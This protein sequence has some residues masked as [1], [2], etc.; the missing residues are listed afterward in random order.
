MLARE[1]RG[2]PPAAGVPACPPFPHGPHWHFRSAARVLLSAAGRRS[3]DRADPPLRRSEADAVAEWSSLPARRCGVVRGAD[4]LPQRGKWRVP[5]GF[6]EPG[7]MG[8]ELW[9][10]RPPDSKATAHVRFWQAEASGRLAQLGERLPYKQEVAGSI[11][12]PPI[13]QWK[14]GFGYA[15]AMTT[16][17]G[18]SFWAHVREPRPHMSGAAA[19]AGMRMVVLNDPGS[20]R[21]QRRTSAMRR[22]R[23]GGWV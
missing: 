2:D 1:G 3:V 21:E 6:G 17:I 9:L 8:V 18:F 14:S 10:T 12:A 23:L 11:P 20:V 4:M 5:G 22:Q 19:D 15:E 7:L 16:S 13:H